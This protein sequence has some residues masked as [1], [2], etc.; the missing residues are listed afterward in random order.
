MVSLYA[1]LN[2]RT[3]E[4]IGKIADHHT[5]E[6]FVAFLTMVVA[7]QPPSPRDTCHS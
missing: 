2:T 1:T 7:T 4:V 5:S 3:G 6:E